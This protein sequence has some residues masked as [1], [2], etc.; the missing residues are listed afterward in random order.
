MKSHES[1]KAPKETR[2]I[3]NAIEKVVGRPFSNDT[4]ES[5][6]KEYL[7][8]LGLEVPAI[9]RKYWRIKNERGKNLNLDL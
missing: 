4:I 6:F 5:K 9:E 3:N 1:N 7:E 2:E 8:S